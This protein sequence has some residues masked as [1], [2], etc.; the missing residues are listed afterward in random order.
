MPDGLDTCGIQCYSGVG[1]AVFDQLVKQRQSQQAVTF[2]VRMDMIRKKLLAE[3]SMVMVC[4]IRL[5]KD[6][7]KIDQWNLFSGCKLLDDLLHGCQYAQRCDVFLDCASECLLCLVILTHT[8][9]HLADFEMKLCMAVID[10]QC[11]SIK[12][13]CP[14]GITAVLESCSLLIQ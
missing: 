9:K 12:G 3:N 14:T 4:E 1:R 7:R 5:P 8:E 11:L 13:Q 10:L 2:H 6:V